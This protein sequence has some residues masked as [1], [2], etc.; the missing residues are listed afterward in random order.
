MALL[1]A[2][3]PGAPLAHWGLM[4]VAN[5]G[6]GAAGGILVALCIVR[7]DSIVKSIAVAASIVLT[8]VSSSALLGGPMTLPIAIASAVVIIATANYTF[9]PA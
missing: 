8:A 2:P 7:F 5:S 6:I 3:R 1:D 4:E 9:S